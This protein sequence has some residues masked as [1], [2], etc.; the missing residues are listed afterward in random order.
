MWETWDTV[1][2]AR[3][4]RSSVLGQPLLKKYRQYQGKPTGKNGRWKRREGFES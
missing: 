4:F 2:D 3:L 1:G